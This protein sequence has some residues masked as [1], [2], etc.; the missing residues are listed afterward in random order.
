MS[1]LNPGSLEK[2]QM[3]RKLNDDRSLDDDSLLYVISFV[4][5]R[6][7]EASGIYFQSK[8]LKI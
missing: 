2:E 3:L 4:D 8:V 5:A 1:S 7:S 6:K